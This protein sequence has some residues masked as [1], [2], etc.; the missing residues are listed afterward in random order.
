MGVSWGEWRA[1]DRGNGQDGFLLVEVLATMTISAL[2]LAAL[3]SI[4]SMTMRI[5]SRIERQ[6]EQIEDRTRLLAALSR[7]VARAT[8]VRWAGKNGAFVFSGNQ[9]SLAFAA[10]FPSPNGGSEV[11]AVF[12]D[13]SG[14]ITRR[15]A[16]I[17]P[18]AASFDGITIG[19]VEA[20]SDGRYKLA[21]AYFA[22]LG[23]GREALV[24][25]W[26]DASQFP[27]AIRITL[28]G[29]DGTMSSTRLKFAVDAEPGCGFPDTGRCS[30][31]P[32]KKR[33]AISPSLDRNG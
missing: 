14:A 10:E 3:F 24:E 9:R 6:T 26:P 31:R 17:G 20:M 33:A 19:Q 8:P 11:K 5:S 12:I 13:S 1:G 32:I 18:A 23:D 30:L 2:L 25:T 16:E 29:A 21:F 22:R 27:V 7:E 28:S 15:I 4:T